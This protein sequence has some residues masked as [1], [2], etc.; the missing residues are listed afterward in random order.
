MTETYYK[1]AVGALLLFDV[2]RT[3]TYVHGLTKWKVDLDKKVSFPDLGIPIPAVLVGTKVRFFFFILLWP[4]KGGTIGLVI[5]GPVEP[6]G[7]LWEPFVGILLGSSGS[8]GSCGV[9]WGPL[10]SFG[11]LRGPVGILCWDSFRVLW[12]L[13]VLWGPLASFGSFGVF[14]GPLGSFGPLRSHSYSL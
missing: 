12:V 10:G 11:V 9:L 14:W 5:W 6:F 7:V 2:S 1:G 13:W 3:S 4:C 8:F